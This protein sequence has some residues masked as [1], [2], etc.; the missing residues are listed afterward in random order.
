[1][2][3]DTTTRRGGWGVLVLLC[4]AQF[5]LIVDITVVQVALPTIGTDL[6]LDRESLTWVV[7]TYT[8]CF[9]GLMVLGGRL[10]DAA[11]ARR[12]LLAGLVLFTAASLICGLAGSG[13]MLIAG[14]ALQGVG[15]A[16]LSPAAL[17]VITTTFHGER[18]GRALGVWAAIGGTGAALG[19]L[20]GGLLTEG[21]GW[22][23]VFFVNVPIGLLVLAAVPVV[24]P[25]AEAG[26][27]PRERVDVPGALVVTLATALLI[28]GLVTAGDAGWTAAGT[29]LPLAGAVLLYALFVVVERSVRSPLMRAET[30]ARRPVISGMFVM[31]IATGLMLGLFFLSSLYLQHVLGFGALETGLLF[32]PVAVA[33][34]I[35]AQ[36]GGHLIGKVG[37]RPVAVASFVLTAAGAALMTRISPDAGAYTTLLPG[38]VLAALGIG[39]AFVT[40]TTTTMANIPPGENGVASGVISTFHELGGSIGVAVVST[41]AAASLAP[42]ATADA[43]GFVAGFTLCAVVAGVTAVVALGLVP[44]G[45]PAAAFVGHGH[46][47]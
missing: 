47:H 4:L 31:L 43:G 33:I 35:G 5:M 30:L 24:L 46:G 34:T 21:P 15:A 27:G 17:A 16:L 13:A 41:V 18:R 22:T 11:G 14:R 25:G 20:V 42:G 12:T 28:Y 38:F 2:D 23:W 37:G 44:P 3:L 19:V 36:L 40:A 29:A 39:P 9:G 32:L 1:M 6:A 45:R 26:A 7:T 8:L 10:A